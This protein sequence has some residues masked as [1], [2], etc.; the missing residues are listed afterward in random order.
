[1]LRNAEQR[2]TGE[3]ENVIL[4]NFFKVRKSACSLRVCVCLCVCVC[5]RAHDCLNLFVGLHKPATSFNTCSPF[6][7][8]LL[9]IYL[10]QEHASA[11]FEY[12]CAVLKQLGQ[13]YRHCSTSNISVYIC[14]KAC[15]SSASLDLPRHDRG[16]SAR[17]LRAWEGGSDL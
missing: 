1:M 4:F 10:Q 15:I 7:Y 9:K 6:I 13:L 2:H 5:A 14:R 8:T 3:N 11:R 16:R 12:V 17:W